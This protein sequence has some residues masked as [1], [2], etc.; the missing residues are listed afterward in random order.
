MNALN[1]NTGKKLSNNIE[2]ANNLLKR[3]KGLLGK[4]EMLDGEALWIKP[5]ISVHTFFMKFPIDIVFLNK[6][7]QVIAAIRNLQPNHITRLYSK[8]AS[9]LELPAGILEATNTRVG[10]E[11]EIA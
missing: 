9:V 5:C 7:N 3:M 4:K 8:A 11:I 1:L 10:D 2:V 6:R